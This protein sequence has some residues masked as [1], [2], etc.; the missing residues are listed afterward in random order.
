[1]IN[2]QEHIY[3]DD[4]QQ[5]HPDVCTVLKNVSYFFL[6]NGLIQAAVQHSPEGEGSP[7]GLI[8]MDPE[9]LKPKRGSLN[10]DHERGFERT[11]IRI[12][13]ITQ[14]RDYAPKSIEA[15]W[16]E[17]RYIPTVLLKWIA[18]N[19]PVTELFFCP[20]RTTPS[21][22]R[23]VT[24][25][26]PQNSSATLSLSTSVLDR[27]I[28]KEVV[29][30]PN[31]EKTVD[32]LY[33][34]NE[35]NSVSIQ[36]SSAGASI[37]EAQKYWQTP[38]KLD[39]N[40]PRL[41]RFFSSSAAQLASV[42][43]NTGRIDASIW[44]Y[45]R[46][47]VRDHS[48][49]AMGL[50]LSGH[51]SRAAIL[52]KRLLCDFISDEGDAVDSSERRDPDEVELDQ[53]GI[54]LWTLKNYY[55]WTGDR[56]LI[57]ENWRK[58]F[59]CAEFPLKKRFR[60]EPSGLLTNRR[61]FWERHSA[62]G[63]QPGLELMYQ[64]FPS[65]GL[66]SAAY[67]ARI[68]SREKLAIRWQKEAQRLKDAV[69]RHSDFSMVDAR[70]F[71]KRRGL[72]GNVQEIITPVADSG[73]PDG[74]PLAAKSNHYVNPDSSSALPIALGFIPP[75]SP[76]AKTT[77]EQME[78]LW[79]QDWN[80]GGYGRYH[81]SSEAD[82]AGPWPF[83]S[84]FIARAYLEAGNY[85]KVWRVLRWLDS[86]PGS[87]S[88]SWFEMYGPRIAPPY[89]Q[90]GI[91]PWTWAEIIMLL[92]HHILGI[93]PEEDALIICPRLLPGMKKVSGSVPLQNYWL[94]INFNVSES[95]TYPVFQCSA[96]D[97]NLEE[98]AIRI[99]YINDDIKIEAT[100]PKK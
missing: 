87:A 60:H 100:F 9:H 11:Q 23:Q 78:I 96:G 48:F 57:S 55:L 33:T 39:F 26:N 72:D 32:F 61:E 68:L 1:M 79:N 93:R 71:I 35:D 66:S 52:L 13:N 20:D 37:V 56:D 45:C 73:L 94:H 19:F 91:T 86:L 85:E 50:I 12:Q 46:E 25:T 83:A 15:K 75:D 18:G 49:M 67:L 6:G 98:N 95:I 28:E 43:S 58:I 42:I 44:Q 4:P 16:D 41:N 34:L 31:E 27:I 8:L 22:L 84:L 99:P 40:D 17:K 29:L 30:Q 63:I 65:I 2:V 3:Q 54:L 14:T 38:A 47:W 36:S 74:V 59:A 5:G 82:S 53:N 90:V 21:L 24:V 51:H 62:H 10:F 69:L 80:I 88:G 97:F 89:A 7:I 64:V 92:M 77:L 76:L 70:G 81:C